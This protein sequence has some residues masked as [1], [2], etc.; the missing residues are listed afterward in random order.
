MKTTLFFMSFII[1]LFLT[2]ATTVFAEKEDDIL[3]QWYSEN[4]ESLIE[5]YKHEGLFYG[6]L[7]W[8]KEPM[9]RGDYKKDDFNPDEKLRDRLLIGLVILKW[10]KFDGD[11]EWKDGKIYDPKNGKTYNCYMEFEKQDVLKIRGYVGIS[12]IGRSTYWTRKKN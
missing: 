9:R 12:L 10:F 2:Q 11:N 8:L 6:K 1:A 5:I 3:G 4:N 7:I